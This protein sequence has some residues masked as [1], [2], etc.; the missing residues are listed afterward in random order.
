VFAVQA[1]AP[2]IAG[3]DHIF[4][5]MTHDVLRQMP[6]KLFRAPVPKADQPIPVHEVNPHRQFFHHMPEQLRIVEKV[7]RNGKP[8]RPG[9]IIPVETGLAR[10]RDKP[11]PLQ[12]NRRPVRGRASEFDFFRRLYF[13]RQ[14]RR[15]TS[16]GREC[17]GAT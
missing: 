17:L 12:K 5:N 1:V 7:R 8:R 15:G 16:G 4:E 9:R 3:L 11:A 10:S 14:P 13:H 6:G 2:P